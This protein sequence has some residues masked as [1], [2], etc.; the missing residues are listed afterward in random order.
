MIITFDDDRLYTTQAV[1]ALILEA[2]HRPKQGLCVCIVYFYVY[3]YM[4]VCMCGRVYASM[5]VYVFFF[6]YVRVDGCVCG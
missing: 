5:R 3:A 4:Y 1:Q 6:T 2:G